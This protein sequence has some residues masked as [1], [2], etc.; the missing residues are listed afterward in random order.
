MNTLFKYFKRME[1][2]RETYS[3]TANDIIKVNE[4]V[5]K[6]LKVKGRPAKYNTYTPG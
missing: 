6:A 5:V 4:S 3:L 2:P 1:G